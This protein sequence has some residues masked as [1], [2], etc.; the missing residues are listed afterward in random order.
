MERKRLNM[1][2]T[3]KTITDNT[4]NPDILKYTVGD[5]PVLDRDLVYWDCLGTAAHVRMLSEME[6]ETPIVTD[7]EARKVVSARKSI[8]AS[9]AMTRLP[10]ISVCISETKFSRRKAR[11]WRFARRL[12]KWDART[13]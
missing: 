11:R 2:K 12:W 3:E 8:L 1:N 10:S 6:L 9:V 4:V 7:D 5:D 13:P